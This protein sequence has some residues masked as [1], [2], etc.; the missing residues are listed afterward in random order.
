V[1][2]SADER[3][4]LPGLEPFVREVPAQETDEATRPAPPP[5]PL[6]RARQAA[7]RDELGR[8][9]DLRALARDQAAQ[10]R[11]QTAGRR[12]GSARS[13]NDSP[14]Q[15]LI[16]TLRRSLAQARAWAAE[17]RARAAAD[18]EEAAADRA[19]ARLDRR[20]ARVELARAHLDGL[21][22]VYT[23]GLGED[24]L[25]HEIDRAHRMKEPFALA[26][27][28]VDRLKDVND[29]EGHAAGDA[30]LCAVVGAMRSELRSYD[31][32]VRVG[33]D[34]FICGLT[35]TK[36]EAAHRRVDQIRG[37]VAAETASSSIS[38]GLAQLAEGDTLEEL[39]ARGDAD[40][41][42]AKRGRGA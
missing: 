12:A 17:D 4:I 42:R 1:S 40:L 41:Y 9:R 20:Q 27:V 5:T 30:V 39:A 8:R 22:G 14:A 38:V 35:A 2:E 10:A 3:G 26:F 21:T 6:D 24:I 7:R 36:T 29:R 32:I 25:R 23:R 15:T 11:D 37:T 16:L 28:D 13:G 31:P 33:G 34:E 19:Q 18:R